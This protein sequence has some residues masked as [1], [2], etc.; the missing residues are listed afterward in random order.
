M[1]V[2]DNC[3]PEKKKET[4]KDPDTYILGC[5]KLLCAL[6]ECFKSVIEIFFNIIFVCTG[7]HKKL[8]LQWNFPFED[9]SKI[10]EEYL[11]LCSECVKLLAKLFKS[12]QL[13][14]HLQGKEISSKV[15]SIEDFKQYS[16]L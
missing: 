12:G 9:M 16:S 6:C 1:Y 2:L 8:Y 5:S 4:S 10:S 13:C 14:S 11:D 15:S 7:Y 3:Y